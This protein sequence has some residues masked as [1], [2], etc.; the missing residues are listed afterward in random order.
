MTSSLS[1]DNNS[2]D[3]ISDSADTAVQPSSS[4]R[5]SFLL[6]HPMYELLIQETRKTNKNLTFQQQLLEVEKVIM[7]MDNNNLNNNNNNNNNSITNK[8]ATNNS[9]EHVN[10]VGQHNVTV[11]NQIIAGSNSHIHVALSDNS[12]RY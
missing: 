2:N 12:H 6:K 7:T 8:N 10:L 4:S 1:P 3:T 11:Q 9:P 5:L